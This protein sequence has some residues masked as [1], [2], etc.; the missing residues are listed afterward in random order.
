LFDRGVTQL[1]YE[2]DSEP[3]AKARDE[4]LA[5]L[6]TE[7][8]IEVEG[9]HSHTLHDLDSYMAK[10]KPGSLPPS[11]MT[12]FLKIFEGLGGVPECA[13]D[14]TAADVPNAAGPADPKYA[15]PTLTEMGYPEITPPLKVLFP[16]GETEGLARMERH[17]ARETWICE[18]E[19]PKTSPNSLSPATTVLS[20]HLKFGCV[21]ARLFY[22]RL[23]KVYAANKKHTKPPVS[24]H[25][26]ML[27]REFYYLNG[28]GVPNYDT[29]K[30]N[31]LCKQIPWAEDAALLA[32]WKESRTGFPFIDAIMTQ[33]RLEGWIHHLARHA[34]ACFL[35]RGDLWQSWEAGAMVFDELLLDA[36]WSINTGNWMWLSCSAY[37]YQYFRCYSP[38]AF[39]KKTDPEGLYIKKYLPQL[40]KFPKKYIYEPWTAPPVVQKAAGCIIGKDY[41]KPIVDHKVASKE[42]MGK[43]KA[44]YDAGKAA[45]AGGGGGKKRK[46]AG[47]GGGAKA[48]KPKP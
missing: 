35:T 14:L 10:S 9:H 31:P 37:F 46:E 22:H 7:A 23:A 16:G 47:E 26:Q 41:P 5:K 42:N 1:T 28:H 11:T 48:K 32:A 27:W 36:D 2:V 39:G 38:V 30:G 40:S 3:Y 45:I 24:L 12:S 18:F 13:P 43:M 8:S 19:K 34:V 6:A 4:K 33:L 15:V 44:A 25:G 17:L 20:P 29:M 21:S